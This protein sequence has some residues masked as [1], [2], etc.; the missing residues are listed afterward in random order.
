MAPKASVL[1]SKTEDVATED[2]AE[3]DHY[4]EGLEW[5][6]SQGADIF[7]ASLGYID[8]Y[9]FEQLDGKSAV[10]TIAAET[11]SENGLIVFAPMGNL[12]PDPRT[13]VAPADAPSVL[14]IGA[15]DLDG[16]L[17]N[18]SSR[19]PTADGRIK[20][21]LMASGQDVT[22]VRYGSEDEYRSGNGTSFATPIAAGIGALLLQ[23]DPTLT[24]STMAERLRETASRSGMPDSDNGYGIVH[25]LRA[26]GESCPCAD[27][28]MDGFLDRVCGGKDCEDADADV[29][30]SA[31]EQCF[32][33]IDDDCDMMVDNLDPDCV[34]DV[35]E[36]GED[37]EEGVDEAGVDEESA[38]EGES[39]GEEPEDEND[40]GTGA[41]DDDPGTDT[42]PEEEEESGGTGSTDG[43][44][45]EEGG[46]EE[47][48]C[49]CTVESRERGPLS[50]ALSLALLVGF[51]RRGRSAPLR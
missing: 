41:T 2:E 34:E 3:E 16:K 24:P 4:V 43:A 37:G 20:P 19:G 9:D 14:S 17:S 48:G 35:A 40:A 45:S 25:A 10:V 47:K 36:T 23:A 46:S 39:G 29:N 26:A 31:V 22:T 51:R 30:P 1:L 28:D 18:F 44:E 5:I 8:W 27:E 32:N 13:I 7:T 6:E 50:V 11:A 33:G 38:G 21:D 42:E 15:V 49:A 12:G